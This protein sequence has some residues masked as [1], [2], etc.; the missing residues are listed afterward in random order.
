[1][2]DPR[3]GIGRPPAG[4]T[5]REYEARKWDCYFKDSIL[6]EEIVAVHEPWHFRYRYI[7]KYGLVDRVR[8][9]EY[10]YLLETPEYA[11]AI[12][13]ILSS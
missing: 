12:R 9:G 8:A 7:V 13:K 11:P 3:W 1:M 2:D 5:P 4:D 6:P 10:D